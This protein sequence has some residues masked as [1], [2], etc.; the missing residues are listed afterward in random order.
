[1]KKYLKIFAFVILLMIIFRGFIFRNTV[2]YK[3]IN[4]QS[5]YK[6]T[7]N[8]FR[9]FIEKQPS[10]EDI[11]KTIRQAL[12]LTAKQLHFAANQKSTNPN[13]LFHKKAAH[14]VG[15]A[16]YFSTLCNELLKKTGLNKNWQVKHIRGEIYFLGI[17]MHRYSN[18]PF[19]Q[20]HDFNIVENKTTG[21]TY[22][23]DATITD[24]LKIY[25]VQ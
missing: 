17:N 15:Y 13:N 1:M 21:E 22:M 2:T 10:K 8:D 24:Y 20:D 23:V 16:A 4:T 6:I 12:T 25:Y 18:S 11:E 19:F 3:P 7:D 9:L 14:C 5:I